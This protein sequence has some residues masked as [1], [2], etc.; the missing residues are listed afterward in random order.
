MSS[1][2][3]ELDDLVRDALTADIDDRTPA[4]ALIERAVKRRRR[5]RAG[6]F[7]VVLAISVATALIAVP[8]AASRPDHLEVVTRSPASEQGDLSVTCGPNGPAVSSTHAQ[9]HR[10]GVHILLRFAS[11]RGGVFGYTSADPSSATKSQGFDGS[12][13]WNRV[14]PIPPGEVIFS[15]SGATDGTARGTRLVEVRDPR[16]YWA[17]PAELSCALTTLS[18]TASGP[19]AADAVRAWLAGHGKADERVQTAGYPRSA[20]PTLILTRGATAIGRLVLT[21][22]GGA[23]NAWRFDGTMCK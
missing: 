13:P 20:M 14:E 23:A 16:H 9:A 1:A 18:G 8:F 15:C 7:G 21:R 10:D 17:A 11:S 3:S 5:R 19:R 4:S 22:A 6:Q 2:P 12:G